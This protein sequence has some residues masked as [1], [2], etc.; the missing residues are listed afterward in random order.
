MRATCYIMRDGVD[1][2]VRVVGYDRYI[3]IANAVERACRV[4]VGT[5]GDVCT[6]ARL[7]VLSYYRKECAGGIFQV[8]EGGTS[9]RL[10]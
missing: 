9:K 2:G 8:D 4:A 3:D 5:S 10:V 6:P 7:V 1:T